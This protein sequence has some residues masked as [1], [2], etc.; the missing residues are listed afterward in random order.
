MRAKDVHASPTNCDI[1]ISNPSRSGSFVRESTEDVIEFAGMAFEIFGFT[2]VPE[3]VA[4]Y[5]RSLANGRVGVV[6]AVCP[7]ESE[8]VSFGPEFMEDG[9]VGGSFVNTPEL[10]IGSK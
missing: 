8:D 4:W 6:T 3:R 2:R 9:R 7:V 10:G 1:G 5:G